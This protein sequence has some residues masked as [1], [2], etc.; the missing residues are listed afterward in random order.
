[1][2]FSSKVLRCELSPMRKFH[3][4]ALAAAAA[5]KKIYHLNIGQPDVATPPALFDAVRAFHERTLAYAPS[6]GMPET[7][8]AVCKYYHRIGVDITPEDVL[9]TTGGSEALQIAFN[10][11]LD[12]GD[13]VILAE[14]F[15]P[16]YSTFIRTA[17]AAIHPIPTRAEEGFFYASREKLE[18]ALTPRT[19]AI[20]VTNPGNPTGTVLTHA[21]MELLLDFAKQHDLFLIADEVYRE[22]VYSD[23]PLSSFAQ[24]AGSEENL[25]ITDS[26]SKRFS[27]CGARIGCLISRPDAR[28]DGAAAGLCKAA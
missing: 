27:A 28:A 3:P 26:V 2:Q 1:M 13:E 19:R 10:C 14:P 5:G 18:A 21:Q 8:D 9:I 15:Y 6:P 20:L 7:I 12:E 16:N 4:Y 11:I 25:I 24:L 23:E 22:F 17:G